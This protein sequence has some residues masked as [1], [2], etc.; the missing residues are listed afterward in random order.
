MVGR[1]EGPKLNMSRS[2][3]EVNKLT[4]STYKVGTTGATHHRASMLSLN[5]TALPAKSPTGVFFFFFLL[6]VTGV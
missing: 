2:V 3:E 1:R 5:V 4:E 6:N